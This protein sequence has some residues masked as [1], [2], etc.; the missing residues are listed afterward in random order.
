MIRI[1]L[2]TCGTNANYHIAR[3]LKEKFGCDFRVIGTDINKRWQIPTSPYL[4]VFYQCPLTANT[5]YYQF[6]LNV[7]KKEKVDYILPSFDSDQQLF[8]DGNCDLLKIGVKSL[9]IDDQLKKFYRSKVLMNELLIKN[10]LPVP[11]IYSLAEIEDKKSYFVKPKGGVGSVG[12]MVMKGN[13]IN[14]DLASSNLIEEVCDTPEITLEC[15]FFKGK[16]FSIARQRIAQKSGVCTKSKV[17]Y[18]PE[19]TEIAQRFADSISLPCIFNLQ[20]MRNSKNKFVITDVNLRAAGGMSMSYAAGWDEVS[21]L[22]NIL[23]GKSDEEVIRH[24]LPVKQEQYV[25]RAYTDI[26]TKRIVKRIA[27]DLDGTLLDSR[28]RHKIVLDDVLKEFNIELDTDELLKYKAEGH[29]NV[30]WLLSKGMDKDIAAAIQTRWIE[31]IE[32]PEYLAKDNL[33]DGIIGLLDEWSRTNELFLITGRNNE[34]NARQQIDRL[35]I[36]QFFSNVEIV[37][38]DSNT[39]TSK[40][41]FLISNGINLIVGD[42]ETDYN[43]ACKANCSFYMLNYGFRSECF[44]KKKGVQSFSDFNHLFCE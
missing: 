23:L 25:M 26:I 44:W 27:F 15:F 36:S 5:G 41:A 33:Y 40:A 2:L 14:L 12:A 11:R 20:F 19:L 7:C 42:S 24:I 31:L 8:Y 34:S 28:D 16:V 21:A 22:A 37:K 9:G 35:G 6:I 38:S 10:G 18:D 29:N 17:Y 30:E 4:D 39:S 13:D 3:V 32:Q 1:L 43:A